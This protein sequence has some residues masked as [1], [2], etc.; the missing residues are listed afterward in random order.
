MKPIC[1]GL[2]QDNPNYRRVT[3][4]IL[5]NCLQLFTTLIHCFTLALYLS[6]HVNIITYDNNNKLHTN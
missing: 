1:P 5:L 2:R 3:N 4:I 6:L